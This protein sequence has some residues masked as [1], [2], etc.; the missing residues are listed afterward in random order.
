VE[1]R[2]AR[3]VAAAMR[4]SSPG[5][6]LDTATRAAMEPRFGHDFSKVRVH[7]DAQA[8]E[9]AQAVNALA[10]TVG[11][12][13]VFA[14]GQYAPG[15]AATNRLLAH[16]L[17]HT[18]Q[19]R[20]NGPLVPDALE[21]DVAGGSAELEAQR[22]EHAMDSS[23]RSFAS[24]PASHAALSMS[25]Q[26]KVN[27]D[28]VSCRANGLTNPNLTGDQAVAAIQ[29]AETDSVELALRA[30]LSLD[31]RLLLARGGQPVDPAFDT[32]LQ[33]ELGLTLTNPAHFPIIQQ[34][35]ERFGKVHDLL[36][37]GSLHYI[38]RGP[39][40]LVGCA[41]A[42]QICAAGNF[43][44][45]CPANNTL[46]FCQPFWDNP[47]Q[48]SATILHEPFHILFTMQRHQPNALRRADASCFESFALRVA[49]RAAFL[50]CVGH[51][52]G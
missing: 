20:H 27:P 7:A 46:F 34:Q 12:D 35:V 40:D 26:R 30:K 42:A 9:S 33:E 11:H 32:I 41:P 52:N 13:V 48:R 24:T 14:K 50:S 49:G 10:Y 2:A 18:L 37:G 28:N 47:D 6:P 4:A 15:T 1:D 39:A 8:E 5:Q 36:A 19:Q 29:A 25:V 44:A 45:S 23:D 51:T 17:T 22:A 16:E 3:A 31:A 38:C 21:V 43:A